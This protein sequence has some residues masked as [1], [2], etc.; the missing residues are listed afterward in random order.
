[1]NKK[2]FYLCTILLMVFFIF[3]CNFQPKI[4]KTQSTIYFPAS[5]LRSVVD[6]DRTAQHFIK[7]ELSGSKEDLGKKEIKTEDIESGTN[8]ELKFTD[9]PIGKKLHITIEITEEKNTNEKILFRG[10][11][12]KIITEQQD[13]ITIQVNAVTESTPTVPSYSDLQ[14]GDL[15]LKDNTVIRYSEN[16]S[17]TEEQKANA[18]AVIFRATTADT[19]ALGVGIKQSRGSWAKRGT[20]AYSTDFTDIHCKVDAEGNITGDL[21]GSDN[22]EQIYERFNVNREFTEEEKEEG[23]NIENYPAFNFAI[24]YPTVFY[25]GND[26]LIELAAENYLAGTAY[27]TGWYLPS[28][29]EFV[30]LENNL[31]IVNEVLVSISGNESDQEGPSHFERDYQEI[32]LEWYWTSSLSET[33]D[34]E[35]NTDP[36]YGFPGNSD[37]DN[38]YQREHS[39]CYLLAIR[40]F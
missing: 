1:M 20:I 21:D 30:E 17:F 6:L 34:G 28:L 2:H 15:I 27:A 38:T 39:G 8:L 5:I 33:D 26:E 4:Q 14:V 40:K 23:Q 32:D 22:W 29:A 11:G 13:T 31:K 10:E 3:S 25:N 18:V 37:A 7:Y 36:Y 35:G 9:I 19:P 24:N 12:E 16:P